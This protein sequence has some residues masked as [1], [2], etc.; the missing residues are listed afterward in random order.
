MPTPI[1]ITVTLDLEEPFDRETLDLYRQTKSMY[2]ALNEFVDELSKVINDNLHD[3]EFCFY[4]KHLGD[5]LTH[6][7]LINIADIFREKFRNILEENRVDL[8][9]LS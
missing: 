1:T 4:K 8:D 9:V 7:K 5:D 2:F 3:H 6:D